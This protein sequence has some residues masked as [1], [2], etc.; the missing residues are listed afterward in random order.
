[1]PAPQWYTLIRFRERPEYLTGVCQARTAAETLVLLDDWEGR[2]G[3][4]TSVVFD[5]HNRPLERAA[6]EWL[7]HGSPP[8][9]Q[10][11]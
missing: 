2:F 4:E 7:T 8:R 3:S 10:L 9:S 5:P 6:L 11:G 1:M